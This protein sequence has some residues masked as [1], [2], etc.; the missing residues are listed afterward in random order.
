MYTHQTGISKK[1]KA[2]SFVR[3][4]RPADTPR[5]FVDAIRRKYAS[6]V[7]NDGIHTQGY[8]AGNESDIRIS[9]KT[10]EEV[11]FEKVRKQFANLQE[12]RIVILNGLCI[13]R[14]QARSSERP[15]AGLESRSNARDVL[16]TCSKVVELDLSR[17]LFEEWDEIIDICKQV[18]RL[19]SLRADGNR[20]RV[21]SSELRGPHFKVLAFEHLKTLSL[22]DTLLSW[23]DVGKQALLPMLPTNVHGS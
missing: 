13:A 21:T 6:E 3:P 8:V 4:S 7:T 20:F 23:T 9:G 14:P 15:A 18:P 22:E 10:V 12:L 19:E 17:N 5:T 11:G 1:P 2:G 16:D